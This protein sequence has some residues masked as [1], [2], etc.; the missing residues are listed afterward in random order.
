MAMP[1]LIAPHTRVHDSFLDAIAEF[2][3]D[4][5]EAHAGHPHDVAGFGDARTGRTASPRGMA[6]VLDPNSPVLRHV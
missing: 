3:A 2:A 5:T 6:Q 1:Q 4:G